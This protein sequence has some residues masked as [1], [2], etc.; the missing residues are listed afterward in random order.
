MW[1]VTHMNLHTSTS[2]W[3]HVTASSFDEAAE[4]SL[5]GLPG[6]RTSG[7]GNFTPSIWLVV[8]SIIYRVLYIPG[9]CLDGGFDFF[10][11]ILIPNLGDGSHFDLYFSTGLQPPNYCGSFGISKFLVEKPR[12][13]LIKTSIFFEMEYYPAWNQEFFSLKINRLEDELHFL[14]A[15]PKNDYPPQKPDICA[16]EN[17]W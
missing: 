14:V 11:T 2:Q 3:R 7:I 5:P 8:Y 1:N 10:W 13:F 15:M 16:P 12:I 4:S 6:Q 9:G 17:G